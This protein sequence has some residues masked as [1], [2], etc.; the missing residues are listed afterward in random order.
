MMIETDVA[1][2][3]VRCTMQFVQIAKRKHRF[4]SSHQKT[5]LYIAETVTKNTRNTKVFTSVIF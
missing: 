5:D 2:L 4:L 3:T 1:V